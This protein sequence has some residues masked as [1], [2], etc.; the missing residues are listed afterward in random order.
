MWFDV[1]ADGNGTWKGKIP[2]GLAGQSYVLLN[3]GREGV[4]EESV[5]AGPA[6]VEV[7]G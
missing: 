2:N 3:Q 5:L 1:S 4:S 7:A 6:I